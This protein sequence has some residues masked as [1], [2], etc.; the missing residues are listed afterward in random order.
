M[1][2]M[3]C[4]RLENSVK[5]SKTVKEVGQFGSGFALVGCRVGE[6]FVCAK[7]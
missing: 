2:N 3:I 6:Y 1:I 4:A 5:M 7:K